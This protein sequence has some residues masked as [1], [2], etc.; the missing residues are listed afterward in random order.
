VIVMRVEFT[1]E[2]F[3]EGQPGPH[4]N[5]PIAAVRAMG[6]D[7]EI[8]PFGTGC[9]VDDQLSADVVA[10]VVRSAFANG[11]THVNIDV[12]DEASAGSAP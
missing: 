2:P 11:A 12:T 4:V 7:V 8:G 9:S 6:V 1:I 10:T 5:E 3:V